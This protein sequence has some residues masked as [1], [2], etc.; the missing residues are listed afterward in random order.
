LDPGTGSDRYERCFLFFDLLVLDVG[1]SD[2]YERCFL[3]FDLLV[4]DVGGSLLLL[5]DFKVLNFSI[6]Q[7]IVIKPVML[8]RPEQSRP[9]PTDQGQGQT[10]SGP[11]P[12][13]S[14]NAKDYDKM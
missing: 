1:G 4:L 11:R 12:R 14:H 7:P 3:F 9:R 13:P 8:T 10:L 6:S 2:R 5:S